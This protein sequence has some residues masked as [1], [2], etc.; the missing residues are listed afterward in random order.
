MRN[1]FHVGAVGRRVEIKNLGREPELTPTE[2]LELAAWL[3][4]TAVPLR[5]GDSAAELAAFL[6]M[7]G[8]VG[9]AELGEA[10]DDALADT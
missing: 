1:K 3:V 9:S 4:A 7:V 5:P 2:A 6:K 8:D 10:V